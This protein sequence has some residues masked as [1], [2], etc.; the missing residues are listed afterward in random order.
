MREI[1]GILVPCALTLL[2]KRPLMP[3]EHD[4]QNVKFSN[5]RVKP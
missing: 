1:L 5:L 2:A 3:K 4:N